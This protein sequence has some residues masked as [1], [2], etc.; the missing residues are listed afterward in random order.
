MKYAALLIVVLALTVFSGSNGLIP[1]SDA[2]SI[3][4]LS[5]I[6]PGYAAVPSEFEFCFCIQCAT[7]ISLLLLASVNVV[8][9]FVT[10]LSANFFGLA[11]TR[12][13][14]ILLY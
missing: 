2:H 10:F 7:N 12:R 3:A 13:T 9:S 6:N 1:P 4:M 5:F 11:P 14:I 8:C